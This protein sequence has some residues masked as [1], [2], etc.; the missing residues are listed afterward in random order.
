MNKHAKYALGYAAIIVLALMI[1][2]V[3]RHGHVCSYFAYQSVNKQV[4][5]PAGQTI[6]FDNVVCSDKS[7]TTNKDGS[8]TVNRKG[9]LSLDLTMVWQSGEQVSTLMYYATLNDRL[10]GGSLGSTTTQPQ[11]QISTRAV[12]ADLCKVRK[13]DVIRIVATSTVG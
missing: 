8:I 3:A 2:Y 10:I 11:P 5:R 7:F 6:A 12:S 9:T 4:L 13:G 1:I